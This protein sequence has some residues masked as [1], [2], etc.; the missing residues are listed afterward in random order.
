[1]GL[2]C[3]PTRAATGSRARLVRAPSLVPDAHRVAEHLLATR[4]DRDLPLERVGVLARGLE[5]LVE[6]VEVA[7][8]ALLHDDLH[9]GLLAVAQLDLDLVLALPIRDALV[10]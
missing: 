5:G 9:R 2:G 8:H 7:R 4:R 1:M 6:Q 10:V 3:Y